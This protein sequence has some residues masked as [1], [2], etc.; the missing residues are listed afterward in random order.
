MKS[1]AIRGPG[2]STG[3][4]S[5]QPV[6]L[7]GPTS[8]P[9]SGLWAA[10]PRHERHR[11]RELAAVGVV[12][13]TLIGSVLSATSGTSSHRSLP[14]ARSTATARSSV[15]LL[16][17]VSA[18]GG[19]VTGQSTKALMAGEEWMI[20]DN[21]LQTLGG[22]GNWQY[23]GCGITT[24]DEPC[25]PG[26][27]PIYTS[28]QTLASD[29]ASHKLSAGS[30]AILDIEP[31]VYTPRV[32]RKH[33]QTYVQAAGQLA[34]ANGIALIAAPYAKSPGTIARLDVTAAAAGAA[35]V[36][37]QAQALN[38]APSAFVSFVR[39]TTAAIH[40]ANPDTKVFAGLSTDNG[41]NPTPVADLVEDFKKTEDIVDG[42]WFNA[43]QWATHAKGCA[44]TGCV[45]T[46]D[47]FFKDIGAPLQ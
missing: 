37:I 20:K 19:A 24:N 26:Q 31:W 39:S 41:G 42:Y 11:L 28:E 30:V 10:R 32:E 23:I 3:T 43:K 9:Q 46:A 17:A 34:K 45:S 21:D 8:G 38:R 1:R 18:D 35:V 12:A 27:A 44:S 15:A 4:R 16:L 47:A 36:D 22:S 25:Q 40:E 5:G 6:T 2:V 33:P 29:I 14:G 13:A 7:L